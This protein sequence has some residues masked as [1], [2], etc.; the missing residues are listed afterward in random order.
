MAFNGHNYNEMPYGDRAIA[1]TRMSEIPAFQD[2]YVHYTKF[3]SGQAL[4]E[5]LQ[6]YLAEGREGMVI[7]RRDAKVYEKRTPARVSIK[8]KK[9][10][11]ET[12]DCFF[13][14]RGTAPTKEYTGKEIETWSY[15]E[16][17][18]TGEKLNEKLYREYQAGHAIVPVTKGYF[19]G[20]YGS[21]EIAVIGK[22]R[23]DIV[24][25]GFLSGLTEEM[26]SNPKEYAFKPIEVTAMEIDYSG[27]VPTLRHGK[28]IGFRDDITI[29]D[30]TLEKYASK[31]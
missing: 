17:V 21:L 30:C 24:P 19:Y 28:M 7:M 9:E 1:L 31:K 4:W 29:D 23:N 22:D 16:E 10:L 3:F 26:K 13:T 14:G 25:I 8:V 5:Q 11:H 20:W 12:V 6:S 2:E 27:T 18:I 15:W